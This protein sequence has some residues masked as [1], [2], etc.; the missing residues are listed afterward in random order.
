[1]L[2]TEDA[3]PAGPPEVNSSTTSSKWCANPMSV[4]FD[5]GTSRG[6]E[7]F[8]NK[9]KGLPENKKFEIIMQPL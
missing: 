2:D 4:D 6:R 8:K 3:A 5:P 1:M 7:I 9:T